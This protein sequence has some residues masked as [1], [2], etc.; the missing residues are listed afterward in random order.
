M[1]IR[2]SAS[3][4]LKSLHTGMDFYRKIRADGH[5]YIINPHIT[6]LGASNGV[7]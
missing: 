3:G 7:R 6:F 4:L 5:V 2:A 1:H